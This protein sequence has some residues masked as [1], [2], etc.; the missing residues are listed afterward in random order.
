MN[1]AMEQ[2][3]ADLP[4]ITT[5]DHRRFLKDGQYAAVLTTKDAGEPVRVIRVGDRSQCVT[6]LRNAYQNDMEARYD[7]ELAL[8]MHTGQNGIRQVSFTLSPEA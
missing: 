1:A 8:M 6:A 2:K 4:I 7:L 5:D 3:R